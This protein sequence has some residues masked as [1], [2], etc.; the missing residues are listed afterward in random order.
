M[1]HGALASKTSTPSS[2]VAGG[3]D[4]RRGGQPA[5]GPAPREAVL[6]AGA[7]ALGV[8]ALDAGQEHLL[9]GALDRAHGEALLEHAVGV[10]LVEARERAAQARR[11]GRPG[12]ALAGQG[13]GRGDVV[14]LLEGRA[15]RL[16]LVEVEL[17]VAAGGAAR[18]GVAEAPLP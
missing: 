7:L 6:G 14:G 5:G 8:E 1:S 4:A 10:D 3:R 18:L 12:A 17:P 16:D 9:D 15:Q 13:D 2:R 11:R